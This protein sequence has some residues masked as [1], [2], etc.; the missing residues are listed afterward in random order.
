MKRED[1]EIRDQAHLMEAE[2]C[3]DR[4]PNIDDIRAHIEAKG[5]RS[6]TIVMWFDDSQKL[7]RW[8]CGISRI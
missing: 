3:H 5:F 7:W 2:G 1:I 6:K 4:E 8:H